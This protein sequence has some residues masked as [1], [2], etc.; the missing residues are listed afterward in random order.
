MDHQGESDTEALATLIERLIARIE[1]S[2]PGIVKSFDSNRQILVVEPA[3]RKIQTID[4]EQTFL[5]VPP[6]IEVPMAFSHAQ[7][8]GFA[9]TVPISQGDSVL[10]E[11]AHKSVDDWVRFGKIQNPAEPVV[12]RHHQITDSLAV[13]G[14]TPVSQALPNYLT[15]GIEMRNRD[16]SSRVTVKDGLVEAFAGPVEMVLNEN[17]QIF[18]VDIG[19]T[20]LEIDGDNETITAQALN[21]VFL[22]GIRMEQH[23]HE[24]DPDSDGDNEQDT[25][26]PKNP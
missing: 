9:L 4:G 23:V 25:E 5:N 14:L 7:T 10:L 26:G 18:R 19:D 2:I 22:N 3:I 12:S 20:F 1:T 24:Q 8:L 6:V 15:D 11:I 13:I 17:D 21:G 16:R